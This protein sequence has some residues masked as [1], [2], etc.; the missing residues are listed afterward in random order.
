MFKIQNM[1]VLAYKLVPREFFEESVILSKMDKNC[2]FG[3]MHPLEL[4]RTAMLKPRQI[5]RSGFLLLDHN[6][7]T[8]VNRLVSGQRIVQLWRNCD[9][10]TGDDDLEKCVL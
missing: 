7:Q 9:F 10:P 2:F 1:R 6:G 3:K 8:R 5:E 4:R